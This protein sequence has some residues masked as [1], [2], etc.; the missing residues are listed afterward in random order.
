[1]GIAC[2]DGQQFNRLGQQSVGRIIASGINQSLGVVTGYTSTG[3]LD[4]SF[5]ENGYFYQPNTTGLYTHAIDTKNRIII[6][7][8]DSSYQVNVS[9]I[10]ADGSGFD[11]SFNSTGTINTG[12]TTYGNE[13]IQVAC[14]ASNNI[15]V[16]RV[17]ASNTT[18]TIYSYTTSGSTLYTAITPALSLTHFSLTDLLIDQSG[19]VNIVGC[20]TGAGQ[21]VIA[22]LLANLS[23]LDTSFN[24]SGSIPGCLKYAIAAGSLQAVTDAII[25]PD[26]RL[27]LVG[28]YN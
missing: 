16:G 28:S 18:V 13:G 1:V 26:G 5:G 22:R 12:Q 23:G 6:G 21:V 2:G 25:H 7:W 15:F 11:T 27:L 4:A 19:L 24:A 17:N 20:D 3:K 8:M 9:R 10:L 14:D